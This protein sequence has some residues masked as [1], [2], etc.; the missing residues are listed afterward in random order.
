MYNT[1]NNIQYVDPN[2]FYYYYADPTFV[3]Q[4]INYVN[5]LVPVK[6]IQ[7]PG[8]MVDN[9]NNYMVQSNVSYGIPQYPQYIQQMPMINNAPAVVNYKSNNNRINNYFMPTQASTSAAIPE[10]QQTPKVFTSLQTAFRNQYNDELHSTKEKHD[11]DKC[12]YCRK[13]TAYLLRPPDLK[14]IYPEA[15]E[16]KLDNFL[17]F[18]NSDLELF[19][20]QTLQKPIET[21]NES[22]Q[23]S[24]FIRFSKAS[25]METPEEPT[26]TLKCEDINFMY[27]SA[28]TAGQGDKEESF[29]PNAN[30]T[31]NDNQ[32]Q[33]QQITNAPIA[34]NWMTNDKTMVTPW[35]TPLIIDPS[36]SPRYDQVFPSLEL[37]ERKKASYEKKI[38]RSNR[39]VSGKT[40]K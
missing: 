19:N 1:L 22:F 4:P 27:S 2:S 31:F 32:E 3:S 6:N 37:S 34:D 8:I 25:Y 40:R 33:Q 24:R 13:A 17:P 7:Q 28:I 26:P 29:A 16:V 38:L 23:F 36:A 39:T 20:K 11:K 14:E 15:Y 21:S 30:S 18:T 9:N 35:K 10:V 5:Y 12:L